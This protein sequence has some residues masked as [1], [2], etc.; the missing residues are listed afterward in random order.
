MRESLRSRDLKKG[1]IKRR[2]VVWHQV[3][4]ISRIQWSEVRE[5]TKL[6]V[7]LRYTSWEVVD[8]LEIN[9]KPCTK[10]LAFEPLVLVR[11]D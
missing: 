10:F 11:E 4:R 6:K 5:E 7:G 2:I 1:G 9:R 3:V 8:Q